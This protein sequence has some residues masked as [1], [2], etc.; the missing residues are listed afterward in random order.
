ML[1]P[2]SSIISAKVAGEGLLTPWAC[3]RVGDWSEGGNGS[4]FTRVF[5]E[6][7][8]QNGKSKELLAGI[9]EQM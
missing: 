1:S 4:I 8:S 7:I 3:S 2:L 5:E 6:L 9:R